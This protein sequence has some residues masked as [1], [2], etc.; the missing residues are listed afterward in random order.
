MSKKGNKHLFPLFFSNFWPLVHVEKWCSVF[1]LS[2]KLNS[3]KSFL[4]TRVWLLVSLWPL[5]VMCTELPQNGWLDLCVISKW[6]FTA[7][8]LHGSFFAAALWCC[9]VLTLTDNYVIFYSSAGLEFWDVC[10]SYIGVKVKIS[11]LCW[12]L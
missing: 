11:F 7:N 1:A 10:S 3:V 5:Y 2:E 9:F 6:Y 8:R 12:V 4:W